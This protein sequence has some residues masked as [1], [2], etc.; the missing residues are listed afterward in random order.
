MNLRELPD[1]SDAYKQVLDL[2]EKKK[3]KEPRWQDDDCDGK[4]Y[5][6]SDVDG[7]TS[8]REKKAKEKA[9]KAEGNQRNPEGSIKD[10]FK[11]KQTDPSKDGFTG[12]GDSIA[13]IM[14]QNAAMKKKAKKEEV[15]LEEAERTK[16]S[17]L[18]RKRKLYDKTAKKAMKDAM[19]TG[20]ASG[21]N[22]FRMSSINTEYEKL[23]DRKEEFEYDLT[24][25]WIDG[26]AEVSGEYFF[27][28][29]LNEDGLEIVMEEVG[30]EDFIEFVTD[31]IEELNEERSARKAKSNAPSYEK[32]KA[33]VDK[34]DAAKKS[35]KKGEYSAAYKKKETDV[36]DYGDK[37]S[38]AKTKSN[39]RLTAT[40]KPGKKAKPEKKAATKAKVEKAVAK[41]KK[42]Q[43]PKPAS[44]PGIIGKIKSAVK[45]GVDRHNKARA[46]GREPEKRVKEFAKGFKSG[47]KDTVKFAG[48]VK[49][50]VSEDVEYLDLTEWLS[51]CID[52]LSED[53]T[54]DEVSDE[55]LVTLFEEA[56][57]DLTEDPDELNEMLVTIDSM[58]LDELV[59]SAI[60]LAA[61]GAQVVGKAA[62][63]AARSKRLKGAA[64]T[65]GQ[66][67]RS[68][69]QKA[70]AAVKSGAEKAGAAIKKHGPGVA[71]KAKA[72]AKSAAKGAVKGAGYAS[73]LAQRA[74]SSAKK[75]WKAGRER[76][77]KKGGSSSSSSGSSSSSSSSSSSKSGSDVPRGA[78]GNPVRIKDKIKQAKGQLSKPKSSGDAKS[79]SSSS[80]S[81]SDG[82]GGKLDKVLSQ[83]RGA[84]G[85]TKTNNAT[86]TDRGDQ[87]E[88]ER[89][90]AGVTP[91][92]R[93]AAAAKSS[94]SGETRKA[95]GNAAK[96][97]AKKGGEVAKKVGS[98]AATKGKEV[99]KAGAKKV[100]SAA[101]KVGGLLK[102]AVKK[103][104]GKTSRLISKGS[105]KLAS[106]LGEDFDRIDNLIESGLF[107]M[108]EIENIIVN[109]AT[110]G[111]EK[112]KESKKATPE[113][114]TGKYYVQG[115]PTA[116]QLAN[117]AKR[118]KIKKLTN[119]GKHKEASALHNEATGLPPET[120]WKRF[121]RRED[122]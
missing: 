23:R 94:S 7:K 36:T 16:A 40:V 90:K 110:Y 20:E 42:T 74:A 37:K 25:E 83:V 34:A 112:K 30:L 85:G 65:A 57:T 106:R 21:H 48:K 13:D 4:W 60:G 33:A 79:S 35:A 82:T 52:E 87:K 1:L 108:H 77:L 32:V 49:K 102:K 98:A 11:S 105:D 120:N 78:G 93:R 17:R 117:R 81:S 59:G 58:Q 29:G 47:V 100:G 38:A 12:I 69:L 116:S 119:Q 5:E 76:G 63:Q 61:K 118:E 66:K 53:E 89:A 80:K 62:K 41:A 2:E 43:P 18:E 45:A 3:S 39:T 56:I 101:K 26:G 75:E 103:G 24:E 68:G 51:H 31:P 114:G 111:G 72:G 84:R 70:G 92:E 91:A 96:A 97:V 54:I 8:K 113:S 44:K 71:A 95:V 64:K 19:D 6:K 9:Y 50:A 99:A 46:K 28:E 55:D 109:E 10:R 73:G 107:E 121:I 122:A 22:R 67:V 88:Y 14:K 27:S 86:R 104:V 15:D 115:K